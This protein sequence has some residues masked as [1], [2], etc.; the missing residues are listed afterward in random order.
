M[1]EN[2]GQLT[3]GERLRG[4]EAEIRR[5]SGHLEEINRELHGRI[6]KH[7]EANEAHLKEL[8]TSVVKDFGARLQELEKHEVAEEAVRTDRKW[9]IGVG[10]PV[11]L[12]LVVNMVM[13]LQVL[14]RVR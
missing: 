6:T 14:V 12:G 1:A 9:L 3:A 8:A 5:I 2:G 10:I 11:V 7:R 4:I 13:L